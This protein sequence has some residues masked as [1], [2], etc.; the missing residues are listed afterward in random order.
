MELQRVHCNS[1]FGIF[2]ALQQLKLLIWINSL[3]DNTQNDCLKLRRNNMLFG[4]NPF[5][6]RKTVT[7]SSC[8][9]LTLETVFQE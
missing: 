5:F 6:S 8:R 1:I 4:G 7:L 3:T 2:V 9:G